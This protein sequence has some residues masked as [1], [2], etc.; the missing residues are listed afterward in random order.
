MA[1]ADEFVVIAPK[2]VLHG[3][4]EQRLG[5]RRLGYRAEGQRGESGELDAGG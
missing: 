4:V 2:V 5:I 1:Q 3:E